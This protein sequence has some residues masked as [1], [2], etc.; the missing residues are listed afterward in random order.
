[1][2][3]TWLNIHILHILYR[4]FYKC[5]RILPWHV[6]KDGNTKSD[7]FVP[8]HTVLE[9]VDDGGD[10][11]LDTGEAGLTHGPWLIHQKNYVRLRH[12]PTC[13]VE[14][15]KKKKSTNFYGFLFHHFVSDLIENHNLFK[16]INR[17][18]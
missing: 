11:V 4:Y 12:R 7:P 15:K 13:W 16:G 8:H 10:E 9:G 17:E 5:V 6:T 3:V 1:M 14:E 18:F 2:F